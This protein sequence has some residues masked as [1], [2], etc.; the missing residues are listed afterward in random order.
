MIIAIATMTEKR[1]YILIQK[2]DPERIGHLKCLI[3]KNLKSLFL[4][5]KVK[6]LL[7]D[8]FKTE[9]NTNISINIYRSRMFFPL[10]QRYFN[11]FQEETSLEQIKDLIYSVE[12]QAQEQ[13]KKSMGTQNNISTILTHQNFQNQN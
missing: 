7:L 10:P 4:E 11:F 5:N 9:D 13:H 6:L 1:I 8:L 3:E 2:I 12:K